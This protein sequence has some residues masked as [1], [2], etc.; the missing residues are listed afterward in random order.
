VVAVVLAVGTVVW[1]VSILGGPV[2]SIGAAVTPARVAVPAVEV[3]RAY[4]EGL[5]VHDWE[6]AEALR[7]DHEGVG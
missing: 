4:L 2:G 7:V 1:A 5:A 3:V 6:T